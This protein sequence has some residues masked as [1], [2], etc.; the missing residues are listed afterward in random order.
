MEVARDDLVEHAARFDGRVRNRHVD[1]L[2]SHRQVAAQPEDIRLG[3]VVRGTISVNPHVIKGDPI[4][5]HVDG[6]PWA[7]VVRRR[8]RDRVGERW[9]PPAG[10][11]ENELCI[12]D[13]KVENL[14]VQRAPE[15]ERTGERAGPKPSG[16]VVDDGDLLSPRIAKLEIDAAYA[17]DGDVIETIDCEAP[18]EA[19]FEHVVHEGD[20]QAA[21]RTQIQVEDEREH[22]RCDERH[23]AHDRHAEEAE[24]RHRS[25][26]RCL[27]SI[28][29][30]NASPR[31]K[32]NAIGRPKMV[33]GSPSAIGSA[34]DGY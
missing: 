24:R 23:D 3:V 15:E 26:T 1:A 30:Q 5:E 22:Q 20:Q 8:R 7:R 17:S 34:L 12:V 19:A 28:A 9:I 27:L 4:D 21:R 11:I 31:P 16:S 25:R 32:A 29:V 14:D 10:R 18:L 13:A 6:S 33:P 2:R